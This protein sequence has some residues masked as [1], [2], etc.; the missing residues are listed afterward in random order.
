MRDYY[1]A[2]LAAWVRRFFALIII[3]SYLTIFEEM[4]LTWVLKLRRTPRIW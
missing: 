1:N 2:F 4:E 3:N